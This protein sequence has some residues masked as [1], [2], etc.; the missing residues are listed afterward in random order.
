MTEH[1]E[2]VDLGVIHLPPT[3]KAFA[4]AL[5]AQFVFGPE[6]TRAGLVTFATDVVDEVPGLTTSES[7][8]DAAIDAI[9]I[10][11]PMTYISIALDTA[12]R[13]LCGDPVDCE[14]A[15]REDA[16]HVLFLLTDGVQ[17]QGGGESEAIASWGRL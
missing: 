14:A 8:I 9:E 13:V 12:V 6:A 2:R 11:T 16:R 15:R 10:T 3:R 17:N 1:T 4:Q 5:A 7:V